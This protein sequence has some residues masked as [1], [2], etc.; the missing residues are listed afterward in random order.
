MREVGAT[1]DD[2]ARWMDVEAGYRR[3]K[4]RATG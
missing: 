4:V 3:T 2:I 1:G